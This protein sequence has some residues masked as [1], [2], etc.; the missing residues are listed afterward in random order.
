MR[1]E[2][3]HRWL[4]IVVYVLWAHVRGGI[5]WLLLLVGVAMLIG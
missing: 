3:L 5:D 1:F 4:R 2:V